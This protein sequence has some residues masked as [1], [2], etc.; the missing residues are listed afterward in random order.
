M[1]ASILSSLNRILRA[2]WACRT[3]EKRCGSASAFLPGLLVMAALAAPATVPES[4]HAHTALAAKT[5]RVLLI[6]SYHPDYPTFYQQID[7]LRE[8]LPDQDVRLDVEFMDSKRFPDQKNLETFHTL[9]QHKLSQLPPYDVVAT[10]DDNALQFMLDYG[11][12]LFGDTP[13]VF[14][15]VN[16]ARRAQTAADLPNITGVR[17]AASIL[18]TVQTAARMLPDLD[19]IYVLSD[20]T[21]TGRVDM[22]KTLDLAPQIESLGLTLQPVD[23]NRLTWDQ[24]M[25]QLSTIDPATGA[26]LLLSPYRDTTGR[27]LA[28]DQSLDLILEHCQAPVLHLWEHGMGDGILG[29]KLVRQFEQGRL[30]GTMVLR[31][32][33]GERP[34][35]IPVLPGDEANRFVFDQRE[36]DRLDIPVTLLPTDAERLYR[37]PSLTDTYFWP[38]IIGLTIIVIQGLI[39]GAL[40]QSRRR[41]HTQQAALQENEERYRAVFEHSPMGLVLVCPDGRIKQCNSEFARL[42]GAPMDA[43]IGF[44]ALNKT[45]HPDVRKALSQALE[46]RH[47]F[48]EAPYTSAL[49]GRTRHLRM[50]FEPLD[51]HSPSRVIVIVEDVTQRK[52][53]ERTLQ[54][55]CALVEHSQEIM[56]VVG[57]D[58]RYRM[59]NAAMLAQRGMERHQ[60]MGRHMREVLGEDVYQQVLPRLERCL[61][62]EHLRFDLNLEYSYLGKRDLEATYSY[63][64]GENGRNPRVAA[65]LRDV[66]DVRRTHEELI[67]AK[68]QAESANQAKSEFLANMSHEIRTPLNGVMGMLQLLDLSELDEHQS[69]YVLAAKQSCMRLTNLLTDILDVSKIE[70]GRLPIR[71]E[72]FPLQEALEDVR[73]LFEDRATNKGLYLDFQQQPNLPDLLVGDS[74]RLRQV[75]F[76]LVG[77][78][79]KFT[80]KG[81]VRLTVSLQ[82]ESPE[83]VRLLF[84]VTDTGIGIADEQIDHVFQVF[85]QV[86]G[87]YRRSY[88]G[89]G[90]GLPIVKRIVTLMD[91]NL[92]VESEPGKGSAFYCSLPFA[93]PEADRRCPE[94]HETAPSCEHCQGGRALVAEDDEINRFV[95]RRLLSKLG[96]EVLDAEDGD[97]ALEL[98]R[99]QACDIV[100]L[101]IQMPRMSGEEV[102]HTL[103]NDPAFGHL[104]E[105]PVLAVTAHAMPGDKERFLEAGA[106]RYLAKPLDNTTL[107]KTVQDVLRPARQ[108][109]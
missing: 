96:M 7:G 93:L 51:L 69:E 86:D 48:F 89:A 102:L 1:F 44:D 66:T 3:R 65:V 61:S 81:G 9:L 78:A 98:L 63:I 84:C 11:T 83:G 76:N 31:I 94:Q 56:G 27:T 26:L 108:R 97:E 72:V 64:P 80:R 43:L 16:N 88:Q 14:F 10:A 17:E 95:L 104:S 40:F 99:K 55:Y 6:S 38:L 19:T 68:D 47:T 2:V 82:S 46:G 106:T 18:P 33:H 73:V 54:D 42:M 21:N 59:V 25:E 50:L 39:M 4:G 30:A 53:D 105:I 32:L 92:A 8:A 77:N 23:L 75:L 41:L 49:G 85:T 71:S 60:V 58:H 35:D 12:A 74:T 20:A 91:G 36:L 45:T 24:A 101:D 107:I 79:V 57:A 15:G 62:G 67:R 5:Y 70:A 100:I 22:D 90:L 52:L 29:G 103:R 87:T 28:F 13:V 37:S 34:S 109:Q